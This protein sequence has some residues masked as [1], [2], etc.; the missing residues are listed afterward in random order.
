LV[1]GYY[2]AFH[3]KYRVYFLL[4]Y[5]NG[6][7]MYYAIR[8]INIMSKNIT[9]FYFGS[10]L[11]SIE[12]LHSINIIYRDVKPENCMID[13]D[14]RVFLIDLGTAKKLKS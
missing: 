13:S 2:K 3:D 14:G 10:V 11:V 7:E 6:I 12:Y 8:E 4:E 1:V 9:R 5:I